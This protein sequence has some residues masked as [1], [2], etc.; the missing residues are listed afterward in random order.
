MKKLFKKLLVFGIYCLGYLSM[1]NISASAVNNSLNTL[2]LN[3]I[4][5]MQGMRS[6]QKDVFI[7]LKIKIN[8]IDV[9]SIKEEVIQE[10][11]NM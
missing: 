3:E 2:T 1:V 5:S 9:D 7:F 10:L 11:N 6:G 4:I 8:D